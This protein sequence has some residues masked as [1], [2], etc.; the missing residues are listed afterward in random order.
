M[1][2]GDLEKRSLNQKIRRIGNIIER[3]K[4]QVA[5]ERLGR[6]VPQYLNQIQGIEFLKEE[7]V[8]Y[9]KYMENQGQSSDCLRFATGHIDE[10]L[11]VPGI[12]EH[13]GIPEAGDII[14][15]GKNLQNPLHVGIWQEE[16]NVISQWSDCGPIM[17][18][19][20][21]QI[22]PMFGRVAF[23]TTYKGRNVRV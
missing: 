12:L 22:I 9:M 5:M 18:H 1:R 2:F 11:M 15:Y 10:N 20:W 8:G 17:I 7:S 16:G 4:I 3:C 14:I 19:K 6:G 21:N 13:N 23:F